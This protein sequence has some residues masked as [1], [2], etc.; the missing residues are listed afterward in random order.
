MPSFGLE[1]RDELLPAVKFQ[2]SKNSDHHVTIASALFYL[3]KARAGAASGAVGARANAATLATTTEPGRRRSSPLR[4]ACREGTHEGIEM[5]LDKGIDIKRPRYGAAG[6]ALVQE[7]HDERV[8]IRIKAAGARVGPARV[9]ALAYA[10][11]ARSVREPI[12]GWSVAWATK[13][14]G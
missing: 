14:V 2:K 9:A 5:H 10:P 8:G 1:S 3:V 11:K 12:N 13:P 7:H 6:I 4:V